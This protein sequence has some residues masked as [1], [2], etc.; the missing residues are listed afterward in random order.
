[1][2]YQ[3]VSKLYDVKGLKENGFGIE[4]YP[5]YNNR[6]K[7][8][9]SVDVVL[10]SFILKGE[11]THFLGDKSYPEKGPSLSVTH[12]GQVHDI[13]TNN[14]G[15]EILNIYLNLENYA[16]PDV[17]EPL[18]GVLHQILPLHPNFYQTP[19]HMT[20]IE[21][22]AESRVTELGRLMYKECASNDKGSVETVRD[23]FKIFLTECCRQALKKG[24]SILGQA[25]PFSLEIMESIRR[26][27]DLHYTEH[28]KIE[29]LAKKAGYTAPYLCRIF[30]EYTGKSVYGY[31]IDKRILTALMLLKTTHSP[32]STIAH[33]SGFSDLSFFN[34]TFR[35][36]IGI[37]PKVYRIAN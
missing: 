6:F 29:T 19:G 11:G 2:K 34:K 5:I 7:N 30:K 9:H 23:Y 22:P 3:Q 24:M 28:I 17:P 16:L 10:L 14:N 27:V 37:S 33:E 12:M 25:K 36:K 32:V 18:R 26:H 31:I 35:K 4:H 1:M 15:M 8:L 21:F 13:I 20:R